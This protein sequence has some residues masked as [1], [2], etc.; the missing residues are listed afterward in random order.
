VC[1][2][3]RNTGICNVIILVSVGYVLQHMH[4]TTTARMVDIHLLL[5]NGQG[6]TQ[7]SR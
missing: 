5:C 2:A 7:A 6:L 4:V 1:S 3:K